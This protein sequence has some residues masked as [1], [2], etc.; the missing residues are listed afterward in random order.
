M[1]TGY[2][3]EGIRQ[4]HATL[5]DARHV[6]KRLCG[7]YVYLRR[8]IKCSTFTFLPLP[9]TSDICWCCC[10]PREN[11]NEW[12]LL[13]FISFLLLVGFFVLNMFVG[14]VVENF[15]KCQERQE[16]EER[17]RRETARLERLERRW[18]GANL[19]VVLL[20]IY[21]VCVFIVYIS[22]R[23]TTWMMEILFSWHCASVVVCVRALCKLGQL[24]NQTVGALNTYSSKMVNNTDLRFHAHVS[25]D[26]PY[27]ISPHVDEVCK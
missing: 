26:I 21:T 1:S 5:L 16:K 17:L 19:L 22:A 11:H 20:S 6:P 18:K 25:S 9:A 27:I 24:A 23:W 3:W 4:V 2:S 12:R 7:G 15:H 8:H 13:Y 14:V 10:Q